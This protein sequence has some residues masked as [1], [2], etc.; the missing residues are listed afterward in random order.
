MSDDCANSF[1]Q[2][3]LDR[4]RFSCPIAVNKKDKRSVGV[5]YEWMCPRRESHELEPTCFI[6]ASD[7][8]NG[9]KIYL[10]LVT[11]K[12]FDVKCRI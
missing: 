10:H 7:S 4:T 8:Q 9:K 2:Y 11:V 5:P 3:T 1:Y 12:S 6:E